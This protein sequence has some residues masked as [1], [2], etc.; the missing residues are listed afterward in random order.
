MVNGTLLAA[1]H[2]VRIPSF[3]WTAARAL[4]GARCTRWLPVAGEDGREYQTLRGR[5]GSKAEI[6]IPQSELIRH[7]ERIHVQPF[8]YL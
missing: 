6:G 1:S 7:E 5:T 8:K 3:G 4:R 2:R